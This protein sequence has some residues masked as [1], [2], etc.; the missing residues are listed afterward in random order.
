MIILLDKEKFKVESSGS[1]E[2]QSSS[3]ATS[4]QRYLPAASSTRIIT[5]KEMMRYLDDFRRNVILAFG[6][7]VP[8]NN[9]C[10]V[11]TDS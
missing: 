1:D 3:T 2:L 4:F 7:C 6:T 10:L 5:A 9:P 11:F 8:L